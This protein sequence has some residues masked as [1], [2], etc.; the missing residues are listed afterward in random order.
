MLEIGDKIFTKYINHNEILER[1]SQIADTINSEYK[2]KDIIIIGILNGSYMFVSDL[3][4]HIDIDCEI[5]FMR[6]KSYDGMNSTNKINDILSCYENIENKHVII[7]EDIVDT[8][9]TISHLKN[10]LKNKN[11]KSIKVCTLLFKKDAYQHKD[12]PEYIGFEIENQFVI[13]YGLDYNNK[14]RNLMDIYKL[15]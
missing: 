14:Y 3:T 13:G 9:N 1:C 11:P 4:K 6:V 2:N 8:G 12:I 5:T 15:S 7:V 10:K